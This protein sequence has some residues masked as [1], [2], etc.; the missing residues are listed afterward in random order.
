MRIFDKVDDAVKFIQ[1]QPTEGENRHALMRPIGYVP[2]QFQVIF[3]KPENPPGEDSGY[4]KIAEPS[5]N[6]WNVDDE[7][8]ADFRRYYEFNND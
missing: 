8:T 4:E 1:S 5:Q 2:S 7:M 6:G 3:R